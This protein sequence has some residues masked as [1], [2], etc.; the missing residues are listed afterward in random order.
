MALHQQAADELGGNQLSGTGE[1]GLREVLGGRGGYGGCFGGGWRY[2][3]VK[4]KL[5]HTMESV[6]FGALLIGIFS[7]CV[8][9]IYGLNKNQLA[10]ALGGFFAC[11]VSGFVLG[12]L[13]AFPMAGLF[14][15]FIRNNSKSTRND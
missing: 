1:E 6:I 2:K 3:L 5:L 15:F 4:A 8:P 14:F 11:I 13:L 12:A 7:G 10:L 9:L